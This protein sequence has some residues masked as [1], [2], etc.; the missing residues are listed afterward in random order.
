MVKELHPD[1]EVVLEFVPYEETVTKTMVAATA[2]SLPDIIMASTGHTPTL[3]T[4][5][6]LLDLNPFIEADGDVN[7]QEFAL[8]VS[9]EFHMGGIACFHHP[10]VIH[11]I[12]PSSDC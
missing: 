3:S 1:I 10:G 9:Q 5:G 4:N 7:T 2:N 8:G 6:L 12:R 11:G